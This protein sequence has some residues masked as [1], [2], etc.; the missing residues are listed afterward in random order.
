[1]FMI[2]E[3]ARNKH[4]AIIINLNNKYFISGQKWRDMR[5]AMSPAYTGSKMKNMLPF[6][7]E[8]AEQM[9]VYFKRE[10]LQEKLTNGKN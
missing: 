3:M 5:V 4:G 2:D 9:I 7:L 1:M 6:V 8:C 10:A